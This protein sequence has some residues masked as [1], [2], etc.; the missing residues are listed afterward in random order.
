[1]SSHTNR[2]MITFIFEQYSFL[3]YKLL[4][5]P[6]VNFTFATLFTQCIS[7]GT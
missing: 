3:P 2:C 1:M 5:N 4:N 6:L 7:Y